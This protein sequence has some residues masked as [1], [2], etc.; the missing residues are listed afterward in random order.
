M[1]H[2][3]NLLYH[4]NRIFGWWNIGM[5]LRSILPQR[6]RTYHIQR[7]DKF[8]LDWHTFYE[9]EDSES[10]TGDTKPKSALERTTVRG[11]PFIDYKIH[12]TEPHWTNEMYDQILLC[13]YIFLWKKCVWWS[14]NYNAVNR[15]LDFYERKLGFLKTSKNTN[16]SYSFFQ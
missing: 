6:N 4:Y 3:S 16:I 2:L 12:Y 14:I 15:P 1:R 5:S 10:S 9:P 8:E 7:T 13:H 11:I